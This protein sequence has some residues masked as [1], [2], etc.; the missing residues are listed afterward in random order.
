[1]NRVSRTGYRYS[2]K[3]KYHLSEILPSLLEGIAGLSRW[4]VR[5]GSKRAAITVG[6]LPKPPCF[7][8]RSPLGG[9]SARG[10]LTTRLSSS[11]CSVRR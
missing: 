4:A 2:V 10:V 1:M 7:V 9:A 6:L 5:P 3:L 11:S 8:S